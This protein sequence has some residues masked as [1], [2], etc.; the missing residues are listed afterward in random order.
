[1]SLKVIGAGFGRTGTASLKLALEK[2]GFG[3]CYHMSEVLTY[4]GRISQWSDAADGAPDWEKIY[5]G[6]ASAVDWPT[7]TFWRELADYYPDAKI[8]LSTRDADKWVEST[9]ETILSPEMW[10][11][12]KP[13]PFGAMTAKVINALFDHKIH[14]H[15][16]LARVFREHEAAVKATIAPERLLAFEA[17]QGWG[18]L[19]EFLGVDAPAEDYPRVNSKEEMKSFN[20]MLDSDAGRAMMRGEG[21]PAEM[22]DKLFQR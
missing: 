14:D 5:D 16:T 8:I 2:L 6:Y 9:Q 10:A 12:L 3:P 22:M 19:C 18:P 4:P 20:A 21:M 7:A 13:M 11:K 17:K 15:E 1:M